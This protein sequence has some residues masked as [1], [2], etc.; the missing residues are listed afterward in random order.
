MAI[1]L[2]ALW[3]IIN[4]RWDFDVLVTGAAAA[5]LIWLFAIF[6]TDW[7]I[8]RE[9]RAVRMLPHLAAYC[10]FLLIEI[11][12]ANIDVLKVIIAKKPDPVIRVFK[13]PLKSRT[14]R[15]ILANSITLTPGTVTVKLEGDTLTVHALTKELA[16]G[17]T[18]FSLEKRLLK[19]EE[20]AYGKSI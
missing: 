11:F 8:K 6:F 20:K 5:L 7:S 4:G 9:I 16:E 15:V 14:A 2:F 13:T 18:D 12:K 1:I 3:L 19:M 10:F 17:L